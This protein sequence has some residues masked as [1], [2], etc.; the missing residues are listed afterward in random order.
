V[1]EDK[2]HPQ[3]PTPGLALAMASISNSG[4]KDP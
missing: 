2:K 4:E 1:H 3:V